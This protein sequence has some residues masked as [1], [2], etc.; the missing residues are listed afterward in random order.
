MSALID[1]PIPDPDREAPRA[2]TRRHSAPTPDALRSTANRSTANRSAATRSAAASHAANHSGTSGG[3][4][5]GTTGKT[6]GKPT[7]KPVDHAAGHSAA[8]L[9]RQ[10]RTGLAEA[11]AETDP[12]QRYAV[13]YLAAL[14]AAAA[15]LALRGRPHRGRARPASAWV[16]LAQL[17]PELREWA[18]Y[19]A[20]GS[21]L[22]A[23]ILA[24]VTRG[25]SQRAADDLTRSAAQFTD[26]VTE[27]VHGDAAVGLIPPAR[28]SRT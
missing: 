27:A 26:L 4:S 6:G 3:T 21:S 13:A 28:R 9:L 11:H 12:A 22:R 25:V 2:G 17:A 10:A 1:F 8:A 20:A 14:R 7:G 24:G 18:E 15:M 19:F 23:G 16:L 5:G